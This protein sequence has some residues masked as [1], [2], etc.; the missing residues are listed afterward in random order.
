MANLSNINNKFIVTD[1]NNGRVLIGATNDIGATLFANHPSTTAPS[2]TFNAPAGQVFENEDLQIAFGLNNASPYN[3]YMQTRFVSAPYYRNLAINPLGGNVGIGTNSP[4]YNFVVSSGGASGVEF[5]IATATGLNEI[6]SYNRSTSV[7]EKLRTQASQFEWYTDATANALVIQSGGNVG[8]GTNSP[9][10]KLEVAS[11]QAK[12]VTSG[13]E[14]ARFGTSNEAS[15]YATLTCEVKGAAAA[16]DRKWIFQ[17]IE[18]GV[19]NAGNIVF[20]PFGGNVGIGTASPTNPLS[21]EATNVS[22]WVAEFKQGHSTAGQSYGV[23][24]FGGTNSSDAAFQVC[25]QAGSGLLRVTGVGDI[26]VQGGDIFLNSGTNYNDKGVVYLSNER[27][28]IIS[29]IVNATANGDTSLDFQTRKS[30]TRASAMF[31]DEFRRVGI[32]TTSTSQKLDV[33]GNIRIRGTNQGIL[34]DTTGADQAARVLVENDY[35]L[36]VSTDRGSAGFGVFGNS[37]IRLGFGTSHTAAQTSLFINSSGNVGIGTSSPAA[38]SQLTLRSSASTGITILSASN[39]GECFINF[40]DNDDANVGQIF[41][42][43]SPDRMAF[44]VGDDTRMTILG[45]NGNVGIGRTAPDYK[46][47]ISNGNAEGIEFGPGFGSGNNLWQNY[48]RTTS[49][50]VKE[51]HYASTYAFLTAGTGNTGDVG[52]GTASPTS[53]VGSGQGGNTTLDVQGPIINKRVMRGWHHCN[54]ITSTNAYRHLKTNLHM[55]GGARGNDE[56]IMGGFEAKAYAYFGSYP[57]FGHGTCMFHN[58]SGSF[59]SLQVANYGTA[60]FMQQ[61][62]VSTD[63]YCVIVLRANTYMQPVIDFSQ[64]YT[65]YPWRT[66]YVTA[67]ISS[68]NLTGVY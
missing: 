64:Y 36:A 5:A 33:A 23:N 16:A 65:P 11:G 48:N 61:P 19:A 14:F 68:N 38:G 47:V 20:Q 58:W 41:Y 3:G 67:E 4:S 35:E 43:H 49:T 28:A 2:L 26:Q 50:Y 55:G 6:L 21:V 8:I 15:N 52:I 25:N 53:I 51:T 17:T 10:A 32:G 9:S 60:G 62:Y 42:G 27:T 57:G 1:G 12:T 31:I 46:L 40:S 44:R 63:G 22:D 24:I 29:D 13:V 39:T 7:F 66:S 56:Y 59:A 45:S 54:P 37:N 30:G 34:L 18:S